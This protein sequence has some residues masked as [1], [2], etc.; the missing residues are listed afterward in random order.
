MVSRLSLSFC[1]QGNTLECEGL[2]ERAEFAQIRGA[3]KVLNFEAEEQWN[4]WELVAACLHM[5][6]IAFGGQHLHHRHRHTHL[7][8]CTAVTPA[9]GM[10]Q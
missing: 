1:C 10:C 3:M 9:W 8:A 4:I 7:C 5:G 6:N 2:D